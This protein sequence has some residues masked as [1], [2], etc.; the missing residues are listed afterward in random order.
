[1]SF[2]IDDHALN[3]PCELSEKK[4]DERFPEVSGKGEFD[5]YCLF[6]RSSSQENGGNKNDGA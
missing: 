5:F 6:N 2:D 1:M 4:A 3:Y